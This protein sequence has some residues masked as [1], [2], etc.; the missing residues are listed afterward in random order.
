V[1]SFVAPLPSKPS[2]A[3]HESFPLRYGWLKKGFDAILT[4]PLA[5]ASDEAMVELGVGKNMVRAIRHWG[6]AFRVW[7]PVGGPRGSGLEPTELGC[8]LLSDDGWDPFIDE[9]GTV[10]LLHSWLV[11]DPEH[12]TTPWYLFARPRVGCFKKSEIVGE[13]DVLASGAIGGR[14][15]ARSTIERDFDVSV[16]LYAHA[17]APDVEDAL[18]SPLTA[19]E[20][21]HATREP[22]AFAL[23]LGGQPS[24]PDGIFAAYFIRW[25]TREPRVAIPFDDVWHA[26]GA[27][28]RVFRLSENALMD[29]LSALV[30]WVPVVQFDETAGIRQLLLHGSLPT[31]ESILHLHYRKGV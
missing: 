29:R 17:R 31:E 27:P 19:L 16:R 22:G 5:L 12:A 23:S 18:D 15:T 11:G 9:V 3:G 30:H 26:A 28:G 21:I 2:F 6:I 7:R 1:R 13:L 25:L 10:W 14:P 4:D 24:L 20:L 8:R